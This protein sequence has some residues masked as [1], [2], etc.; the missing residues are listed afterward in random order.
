MGRHWHVEL[1][2][3]GTYHFVKVKV[4]QSNQIPKVMKI[5]VPEHGGP[6]DEIVDANLEG[7]IILSSGHVSTSKSQSNDTG[8]TGLCLDVDP[9]CDDVTW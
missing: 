6:S 2:T 9:M 8:K 1:N 7:S 3:L 5:G 4:H